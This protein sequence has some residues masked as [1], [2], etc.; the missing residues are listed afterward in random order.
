MTHTGSLT[1]QILSRGQLTQVPPE[2]R[3]P[4]LV[5]AVAFAVGASLFVGTIALIVY[6]L[7]GDFI[8]G[9]VRTLT[10]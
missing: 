4:W 7:A 1:G 5:T 6:A 3:R 10:R 2:K 9:L 8:S